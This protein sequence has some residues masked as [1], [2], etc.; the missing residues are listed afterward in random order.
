MIPRGAI[1]P[2]VQGPLRGK[3]WIVGSSSHGCWLG[4]YEY[5]KQKA[6]QKALAAGHVVFDIGANVGFYTLLASALVQGEGHVYSFE[7]LPRNVDYLR[8][9]IEINRIANCTVIEAAVS[10]ADGKSHFDPS[11]CPSMGHLSPQ[12]EI[13]VKT[14]ALDDVLRSKK[15]RPPDVMKIDVEGAELQVLRG[16][17]HTMKVF[18]PTI[19][20]AT[21]GEIVHSACLRLLIANGYEMESVSHRPIPSTDELVARPRQ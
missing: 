11:H 13:A 3:K 21:H 8:K 12:G 9:H 20:L 4:S 18:R 7:P 16:S 15:I 14:V 1:I 17:T 10:S 5:E 2:I 6:F 19:F